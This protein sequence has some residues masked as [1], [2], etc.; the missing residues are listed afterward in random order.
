LLVS[1]FIGS[2]DGIIRIQISNLPA[3]TYLFRS[4]HLEP[5]SSSGL[6]YAQGISSVVPNTIQ[7]RLGSAIEAIVQ[8]TSMSSAGLNT[9]FIGDADIPTITFPFSAD[10]SSPVTIEL[11]SLYGSGATKYILLNGFEVFSTIP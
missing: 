2:R 11:T 5:I 6:G 8:P 9:T 3:G 7:A 10:G 1:D 4:Y